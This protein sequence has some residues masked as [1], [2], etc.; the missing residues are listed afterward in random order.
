M[1]SR[2]DATAARNT[3]TLGRQCRGQADELAIAVGAAS[4]ERA[5]ISQRT[6]IGAIEE[7][8][9]SRYTGAALHAL[10]VDVRLDGASRAISEWLRFPEVGRS[11]IL[12]LCPELDSIC[13]RLVDEAVQDHR[14]A[15]YLE[16]QR[17]EIERLRADDPVGS[18][19]S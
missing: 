19:R 15:P 14:Y 7:T 18:G 16:R 17:R 11:A 4:I 8:F 9:S 3:D 5:G 2:T 1:T 10:G 6:A 12:M 13:E